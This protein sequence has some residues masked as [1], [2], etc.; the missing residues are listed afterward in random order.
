MLRYNS[1]NSFLFIITISLVNFL[2]C[3]RDPSDPPSPPPPPP[4]TVSAPT[5]TDFAPASGIVGA[6][7]IITGTNF[8]ASVPGNIVRFNGV[9][10]TIT[11]A[12][13]IQ[14]TVTVPTTATTGQISVTVN[15]QTVKSIPPFIVL[16]PP[17]ITSFTPTNGR[18]GDLV[19]IS[20]TNFNLLIA[21]NV[22]KFN[23]TAATISYGTSTQLTVTV[24]PSATS[25]PI[26]VTANGLTA[27]TTSIFTIFDSQVSTFASG[28]DHPEG[29]ALDAA[30]N[31]YV[32]NEY[33]KTIRKITP[34]GVVSIIATLSNPMSSPMGL[35]V[36]ASG[37]IFV[38]D[39]FIDLIWKVTPAGT[40]TV[41]AGR[42]LEGYTDG[43]G[44]L[45]TFNDPHDIAIDG[46]GNLY[47][48]DMDNGVIR[49]ITPAG[50][51]STFAGSDTSRTLDGVGLASGFVSPRGISIDRSGNLYVSD[52]E[53]IRK[54]TPSAVVSTI[55][56]SPGHGFADG[57]ALSAK[58]NNPKGLAIDAAGN[59]YIADKT[60]IRK[61][62]TDGFVITI[63]GTG[64]YGFADGLGS[65][66]KFDFA[67]GIIIDA[68][69]NLFVADAGNN[70]IRKIT[71]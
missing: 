37:N 71:F 16:G 6:Q 51:V 33:D 39:R 19:I 20:G 14:L 48:A 55:A 4:P 13:S 2:S 34:A 38:A 5:I 15:N 69:G 62:T 64:D 49:K 28:F 22:V 10:A 68:S 1:K 24:P 52:F 56:G 26:S 29:I 44:D 23:G 63:A 61:I 43:P 42:G 30:G 57:P 50:F 3:S 67:E 47:V 54:I 66:A 45:A 60:R 36:D 70:R 59:I 35:A 21:T 65:V 8:S 58:F 32:A 12:S 7:V 40:V 18:P 25:G 46:S 27:T 17:T 41:F 31:M 11:S 9:D 53:I